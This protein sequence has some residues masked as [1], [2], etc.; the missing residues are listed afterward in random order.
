MILQSLVCIVCHIYMT[1]IEVGASCCGA[2]CFHRAC[3]TATGG[4]AVT[5][6]R[7]R[8]R[9][10]GISQSDAMPADAFEGL[11]SMRLGQDD[12]DECM[13]LD[14]RFFF[15]MVEKRGGR[16]LAGF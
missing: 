15:P 1:R 2:R 4:A 10:S 16:L 14:Q 7:E 8:C 11:Y 12:A 5:D 6:S 13:Q 3:I 9:A